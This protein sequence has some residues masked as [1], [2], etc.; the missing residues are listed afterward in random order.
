MKI[1]NFIKILFSLAIL[2]NT[3]ALGKKI[4]PKLRSETCFKLQK[5]EKW[6]SLI[7]KM[8]IPQSFCVKSARVEKVY[9]T[10]VAVRIESNDIPQLLIGDIQVTFSN[11]AKHISLPISRYELSKKDSDYFGFAKVDLLFTV[12]K[13]GTLISEFEINGY[14]NETP[15]IQKSDGEFADLIFE[16][17]VRK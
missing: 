12:D 11:G 4:P 5:N 8:H 17:T 7:S 9:T 1:K 13:N 6:D 2:Q 16:K 14:I 15:D 10:Q 3:Y